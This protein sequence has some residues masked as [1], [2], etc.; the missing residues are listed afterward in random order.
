MEKITTKM[1]LSLHIWAAYAKPEQA[2]MQLLSFY[3]IVA[4]T[5]SLS[6]ECKYIIAPWPYQ[7]PDDVCE[8]CDH[9]TSRLKPSESHD[10]LQYCDLLH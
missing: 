7:G 10:A 3:N 9:S 4:W 5:A 6:E 1:A 8:V 2:K